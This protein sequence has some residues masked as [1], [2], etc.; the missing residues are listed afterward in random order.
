MRYAC[1]TYTLTVGDEVCV[2]HTHTHS[3]WAMAVLVKNSSGSVTPL[4]AAARRATR[5]AS[6]L[7]RFRHNQGSDSGK[8]LQRTANQR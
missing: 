7:R 2:H 4:K 8:I 1:T 3:P 6:A 5:S